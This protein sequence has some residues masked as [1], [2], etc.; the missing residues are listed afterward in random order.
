MKTKNENNLFALPATD[1]A[2][3]TKKELQAIQ[4]ELDFY[5]EEFDERSGVLADEQIRIGDEIDQLLTEQTVT[6]DRINAI[7]TV[8]T[9]AIAANDDLYA[10]VQWLED[11]LYRVRN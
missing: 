5:W 11:Q 8:M 6:V 3:P 2:E 9:L 4:D 7:V 1:D 10:R